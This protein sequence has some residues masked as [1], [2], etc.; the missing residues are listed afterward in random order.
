MVEVLATV[1][2]HP[3]FLYLAQHDTGVPKAAPS[4]INEFELAGRLAVFLWSS[5]PDELLLDLARRGKLR[6]PKVLA[7]QVDRMLADPRAKRFTRHFVSQWL[8]LDGL[9]SVDHIRDDQLK[10]A[11]ADEPVA[12]FENMLQANGSVR[13]FIHSD[14]VGVN[15]KL[16]QHYR[17]PDVHGLHFRKVA[18]E[19]RH[20]RG[21]LMTGAAVLAMNSDGKDS[22]PLK[23]GVWMLERMLHDPPP[24]PPPNVPEVDLADPE[25]AKMTLKERIADHR[26]DPACYSC[27]ARID[28]WGIAFEHYDAMGSFRTTIKG[29]PVDATSKLFNNQPLAG[30]EGLKQ[31]LL[32]ERQDQFARAITHKLTAYSLG[33]HLTF[34]DRADVEELT[35]Q[36]RMQGDRLRDLVHLLVQS[37][38][39]NS[40]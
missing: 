27:H 10:N 18:L 30:M 39:F 38:I 29:K 34:A 1:L 6:E 25:I 7:V 4:G 22:H 17:I 28:P 32:A 21:G 12:F 35:T 31:Y 5:I 23:R 13:D 3:E 33:R 9:N 16:A 37:R 40:K 36:F 20:Q 26:D 2:A 14:Y 24:P 8:G 19:A 11:M 15:A